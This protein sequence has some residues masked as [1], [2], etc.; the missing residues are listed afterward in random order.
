MFK[1]AY[2]QGLYS[3]FKLV[4]KFDREQKSRFEIIFHL[5]F[6]R[7]APLT[8]HVAGEKSHAFLILDLSYVFNP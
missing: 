6:E 7:I 1:L 3:A 8:F 2:L 4:R 5:N